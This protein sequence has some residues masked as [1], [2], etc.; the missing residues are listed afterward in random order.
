MVIYMVFLQPKQIKT[1]FKALDTS[2]LSAFSFCSYKTQTD[3]QLL[4]IA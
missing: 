2:F 1:N 4:H 3:K